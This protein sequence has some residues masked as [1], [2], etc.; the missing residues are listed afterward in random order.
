MGRVEDLLTTRAKWLAELS[1]H[2][3]AC[4]QSSPLGH[5]HWPG[6]GGY[7]SWAG[8]TLATFAIQ[9]PKITLAPGT[10]LSENLGKICITIAL[11]TLYHCSN[12]T[13][14][15]GMATPLEP[16][17]TILMY[18]QQGKRKRK[19]KRYP[20]EAAQAAGALPGQFSAGSRREKCTTHPPSVTQSPQANWRAI[21]IKVYRNISWSAKHKSQFII[22]S[23]SKL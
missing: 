20:L 21:L 23:T 2:N 3:A 14:S 18:S 4:S 9:L 13:W 15:H 5:K 6:V 8:R 22:C 17:V 1:F 16:A 11:E 12:V 7:Q 10:E 19:R